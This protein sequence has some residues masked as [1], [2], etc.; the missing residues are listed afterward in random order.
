MLSKLGSNHPDTLTSTN[1]LA[2]TWKE[3][4][5]DAEAIQPIKDCV[6]Q[7]TCIWGVKH[8]VG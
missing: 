2:F 3:L 5:G 6:Q 1:N 4:G 8:Y 7:Q